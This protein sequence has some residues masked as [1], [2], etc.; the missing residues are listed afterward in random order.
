MTILT[1]FPFLLSSSKLILSLCK[2]TSNKTDLFLDH[3][4]SLRQFSEVFIVS[5][6]LPRKSLLLTKATI[7]SFQMPVN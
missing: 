5:S 6:F 2:L 1:V 3:R 7:E 4:L